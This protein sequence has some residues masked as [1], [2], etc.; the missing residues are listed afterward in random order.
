MVH[1]Y[2]GGTSGNTA[3]GNERGRGNADRRART[4]APR[5]TITREL[6]QALADA[7]RARGWSLREAAR[8]IGCAH[9]T[10]AHLERGRR[11][12]SVVMAESIADAYRLDDQWAL[13]LLAEAVEGAGKDSP[14]KTGRR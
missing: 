12:P 4:W 3:S 9:G 10:V 1:T 5:R 2:V 8:R 13:R 6:A 7:R 14:Y 11:A